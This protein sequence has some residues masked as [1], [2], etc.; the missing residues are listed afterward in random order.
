MPYRGVL[1]RGEAWRRRDLPQ[2]SSISLSAE[3]ELRE[4]IVGS[5]Y[6]V[7]EEE[8]QKS[9][10]SSGANRW[11]RHIARY[12]RYIGYNKGKHVI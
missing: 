1:Q 9:P 6:T 5:T 10:I 11:V 7:R 12:Y 4:P 8:S 2:D 3:L